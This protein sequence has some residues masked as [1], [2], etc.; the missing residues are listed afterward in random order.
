MALEGWDYLLDKWA[1]LRK[2]GVRVIRSEMLW[3]AYLVFIKL[4]SCA[5]HCDRRGCLPLKS[6]SFPPMGSLCF[7]MWRTAPTGSFLD[8]RSREAK[9]RELEERMLSKLWAKRVRLQGPTSLNALELVLME[10]KKKLCS[11]NRDYCD[12]AKV[13]VFVVGIPWK[14]HLKAEHIEKLV[15]EFVQYPEGSHVV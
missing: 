15:G 5:R 14:I 1:V 8:V 11:L 9:G 4:R 12:K 10:K 2:Y 3:V 7:C 6:L 13:N